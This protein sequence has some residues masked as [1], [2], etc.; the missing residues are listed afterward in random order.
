MDAIEFDAEARAAII[1]EWHRQQAEPEPPPGDPRP[2]GC[3]TFLLAAVLL[4]V[5]PQLPRFGVTLPPLLAQILFWLLV[6]VLAGGFFI[7]IFVGSGR[8][9]QACQY[10]QES[11]EWLAS[12][13]GLTDP[14]ARRRHAVSL[15]RHSVVR[16][17][18]TTSDTIDA[19]E[20]KA[21]LGR[22]LQYVV[23]VERVLASENLSEVYF[24][25][26]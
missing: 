9:G 25:E 6:V 7:G 13:P 26:R 19:G 16:D 8:Y 3:I 18:P 17:G 22:N 10:A 14:D 24:G 21:K 4:L 1:A 23:A 12:H 5:L 20:A 2:L 15:I 11:L